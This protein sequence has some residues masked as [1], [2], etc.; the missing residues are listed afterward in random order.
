MDTV[1]DVN[2]ASTT[3]TINN[4]YAVVANFE[5]DAVVTFPDPNLEA[6]IRLALNKLFEPIYASRL[7]GLA[8]LSA[9][10]SRIEDLSG[11]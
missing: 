8:S 1:A 5:Q 2:V 9:D 7:A 3:I 4:S 11:L 6:A 10:Y